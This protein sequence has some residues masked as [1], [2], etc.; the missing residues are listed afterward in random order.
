MHIEQLAKFDSHQTEFLDQLREIH[1]QLNIQSK[2]IQKHL[3]NITFARYQSNYPNI[4]LNAKLK[5]LPIDNSGNIIESSL[6]LVNEENIPI[7]DELKLIRLPCESDQFHI[8]NDR[9]QL[10]IIDKNQIPISDPITFKQLTSASIEFEYVNNDQ[11]SVR[12]IETPSHEPIILHVK[13]VSS[14]QSSVSKLQKN[15]NR[16]YQSS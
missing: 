14:D 2:Q 13:S 9:C 16:K 15:F 5:F 7:S 6:Y 8:S 3:S 11:R 1:D 10:T 4:P 12:I